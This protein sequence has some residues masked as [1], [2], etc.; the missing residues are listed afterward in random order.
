MG[1]FG[2]LLALLVSPQIRTYT[3]LNVF[4]AFLCLFVTV[5]IIERFYHHNE[6]L[7]ALA[8]AAILTLGLFDQATPLAVRPYAATKNFF[9]SDAEMV[10]QIEERTPPNASV[11]Q[12]P[13]CASPKQIPSI[14]CPPMMGSG[15]IFTQRI[16]VGASPPCRVVPETPLYA[17]SRSATRTSSSTRSPRSAL[18]ESSSIATATV[19]TR[20]PSRRRCKRF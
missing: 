14:T 8:T 5:F 2:S 15:P 7:G 19:T 18:Q 16:C 6:R 12:L 3:R 10:R 11:F 9:A 1:G 17:T 4:I 13:T 20:Q